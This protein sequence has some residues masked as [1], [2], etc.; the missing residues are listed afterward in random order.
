MNPGAVGDALPTVVSETALSNAFLRKIVEVCIV[1]EDHRRTMAGLVRLGIG[2]FRVYTFDSSN[3]T[4][5]T[6]RGESSPFGLKV[7]FAT[8][9]D[10]TWEIMQPLSGA[11]DHE[12]V[13]RRPR[14][15]D[16]SRGIRL[17]RCS[18]EAAAGD[19]R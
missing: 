2:P 10:L 6:Y 12:G 13:P 1:T 8:N 3:L 11:H 14:R 9:N 19:L 7:C 5:P 4:A 18:V 15:G 17:P 16:P